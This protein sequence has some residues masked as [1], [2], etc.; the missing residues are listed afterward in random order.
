M[1]RKSGGTGPIQWAGWVT[2][3]VAVVGL[4][5]G[6]GAW[7]MNLSSRIAALEQWKEDHRGLHNGTA[8][9]Q[10]PVRQ[11]NPHTRG[12]PVSGRDVDGSVRTLETLEFGPNHPMRTVP[13]PAMEDP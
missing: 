12:V 8:H 2:A 6:G 1:P 11:E 7:G 5:A 3:I 13:V 4:L 10:V 9:E